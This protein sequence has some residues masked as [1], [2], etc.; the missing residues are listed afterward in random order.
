MLTPEDAQMV[1]DFR[2]QML[3]N[4]EAGRPS[5]YGFTEEQLQKGLAALR[6]NRALAAAAAGRKTAGTKVPS[7]GKK[8]S[9]DGALATKADPNDP[10]L[11]IL[12]NLNFD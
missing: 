7:R 5:W 3:E 8:K 4:V 11:A 2:R 1:T 12:A 9:T 10:R 6:S